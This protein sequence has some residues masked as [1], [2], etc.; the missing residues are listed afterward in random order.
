[1]TARSA[2]PAAS[3]AM[4]ASRQAGGDHL[5]L[6]AVQ[7]GGA[8]RPADD[9]PEG[10]TPGRYGQGRWLLTEA[11]QEVID[12]AAGVE[13]E[14]RQ[15]FP[16]SGQHQ[17]VALALIQAGTQRR[18]QLGDLHMQGGLADVQGGRG[19]SEVTVLGENRERAQRV[20]F[21]Q[22]PAGHRTSL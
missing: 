2:R 1:M 9:P 11:G 16:G 15:L 13:R 22:A 3:A 19:G 12:P 21:E 8:D 6:A 18:G 5:D 14:G 17:G 7:A 10:A 20:G 4:A